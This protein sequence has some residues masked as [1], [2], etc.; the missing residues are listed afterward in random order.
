MSQ[1][2]PPVPLSEQERADLVAY[3][4]GE[5]TGEAARAIEAKINLDP[6]M[7]AEADSLKRAW[8]LLDFLPKAPEPA[9]D[10][11]ERTLSRLEALNRPTPHQ[12]LGRWLIAIGLWGLLIVG[13][14]VGGYSGYRWAH[15]REPGEKEL[16]RDL[17]LIENKRYYDRIESFEFL[18]Q[19]DH[20]DLFGDETNP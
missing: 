4:D 2:P 7:R 8:E 12:V 18:Q 1:S 20:P 16:L 13:F 19:L 5:L 6:R 3:L 15:P 9:S 10:F 11:T 14:A 17:R